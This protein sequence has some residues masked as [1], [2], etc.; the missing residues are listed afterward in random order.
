MILG[1]GKYELKTNT[2]YIY[3]ERSNI[4]FTKIEI[5]N[6]GLKKEIA[7]YTYI[8]IF[9]NIRFILKKKENTFFYRKI[10]KS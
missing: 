6:L 3:D 10:S 7:N 2:Y 5:M 8:Y 1:R 4:A 9:F